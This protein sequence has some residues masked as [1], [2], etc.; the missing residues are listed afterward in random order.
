MNDG[1]E[2]K[3]VTTRVPI[4]ERA[5]APELEELNDKLP[6]R[7]D[8]ERLSPRRLARLREDVGNE[9]Q[10]LP[11]LVHSG[12]SEDDPCGRYGLERLL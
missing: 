4:P 8:L 10:E 6:A 5:G 2:T 1:N 12:A 3:N 9:L 11:F 7:S